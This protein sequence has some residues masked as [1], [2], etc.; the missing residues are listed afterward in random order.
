MSKEQFLLVEQEVLD[1][2]EKGAIQKVVPTQGQFLSNLFLVKNDGGSH[3]VINFKNLNKF[4]PYE[5]IK[6]EGLHCLK[7]LLEQNNLLC[8]I[9]PKKVYFSVPIN[10]SFQKFVRFE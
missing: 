6:M 4:I 7:I 10:K 3:P 9:D 8:E 5:H 2:L 1:M